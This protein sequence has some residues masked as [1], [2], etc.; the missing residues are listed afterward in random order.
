MNELR[1][2]V[3]CRDVQVFALGKAHLV[4]ASDC[5]AGM[6]GLPHDAVPLPAARVGQFALRSCLSQLFALGATPASLTVM[7]GNPWQPAGA[8]FTAGL[9][10]ELADAGLPDLPI[11]GSVEVTR[12]TTMSA[13]GVVAFGLAEQLH[14]RRT[15]PGDLLYLLGLPLP[16]AELATADDL[17]R[18]ADLAAW[19]RDHTLGDLLPCGAR[20][21]RHALDVLAEECDLTVKLAGRTDPALLDV[22]AWPATCALLTTPAPLPDQPGLLRLGSLDDPE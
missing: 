1:P 3:T 12:P 16:L 9:H 13:C 21:I 4:V 7:V 17:L 19:R 10:A 2:I 5:P 18:P 14:W 20:G 22:P 15:L 6:G 8:A 11:G